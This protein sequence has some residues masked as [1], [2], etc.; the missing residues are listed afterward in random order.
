MATLRRPTKT[1]VL[2]KLT[3][4]VIVPFA[5]QQLST[6]EKLGSREKM[7]TVENIMPK[8]VMRAATYISC[9]RR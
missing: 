2:V 1:F 8:I 6:V 7:A 5:Q 9:F 4:L 3:V